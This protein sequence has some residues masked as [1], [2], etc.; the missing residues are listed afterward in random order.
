MSERLKVNVDVFKTHQCF[1][2]SLGRQILIIAGEESLRRAL[3]LQAEIKLEEIRQL[4][5]TYPPLDVLR[6]EQEEKLRTR[7]EARRRALIETSN[8][9]PPGQKDYLG[10]LHSVMQGNKGYG[11]GELVAKT[12]EPRRKRHRRK[13]E[14]VA[15]ARAWLEANQ[16]VSLPETPESYW[17]QI[18]SKPEDVESE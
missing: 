17:E 12:S 9:I 5:S 10:K 6:A 1:E 8:L 14:I 15:N 4:A 3:A 2:L 11:I 7:E 16:G 13:G 18:L